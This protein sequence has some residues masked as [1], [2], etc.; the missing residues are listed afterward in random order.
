MMGLN[1]V[2]R[3]DGSYFYEPWFLAVTCS[4][5]GLL[6][7]HRSMDTMAC[8][9]GSWYLTASILL[10]VLPEVFWNI[11]YPQLQF[12]DWGIVQCSCCLLENPG[13]Y[14]FSPFLTVPLRGVNASVN[15]GFWANFTAFSFR[16]GHRCSF[17][18]RVS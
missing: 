5:S 1:R 9:Y 4:V 14:F 18:T 2:F 3:K 7:E 15:G 6:E 11:G 16:G 17:L 8:F 12:I 13:H 10:S